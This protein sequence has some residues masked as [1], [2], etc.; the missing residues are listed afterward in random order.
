MSPFVLAVPFPFIYLITPVYTE[1]Y[2]RMVTP[3]WFI[4]METL[5]R[6]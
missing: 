4:T 2:K 5:R 6:A 1:N 3:A